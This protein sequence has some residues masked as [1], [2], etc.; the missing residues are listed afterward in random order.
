[1]ATSEVMWVENFDFIIFTSI[2]YRE[3]SIVLLRISL[4]L[5]SDNSFQMWIQIE[6]ISK[7]QTH[8]CGLYN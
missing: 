5:I 1:M 6:N 2:L 8:T 7:L 3:R 4:S